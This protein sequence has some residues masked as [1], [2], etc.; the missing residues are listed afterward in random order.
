MARCLAEA[1]GIVTAPLQPG[2]TKEQ[3]NYRPGTQKQHCGNCVMFHFPPGK[4]TGTCDL[5][6]GKIGYAMT[7]D[8]WEAK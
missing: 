4:S 7:C 2:K 3:A 6:I 8:R 1:P 5:V